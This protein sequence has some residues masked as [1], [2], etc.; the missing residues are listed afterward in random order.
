MPK[1]FR[2]HSEVIQRNA[3]KSWTLLH[4][5]IEV[6]LFGE[7]EGV[8]DVAGELGIRHEL[9]VKRNEFGTPLLDSV[10]DRAH[11]IARHPI[12]CYV[13]CDIVLLH[14]FSDAVSKVAAWRDQFLMVGRRWDTDVAELIDFSPPDWGKRLR[15]LALQTNRQ[16]SP[17]WIDYFAFSRGLY[18]QQVPPFAIGRPGYDQWMVWF[19]RNSRAAVVDASG[20]VVAVH[21]NHDYSHH[22]L[23]FQGVMDGEEAQSNARL[24]GG[25][26]HLF[27]IE[28]AQYLLEKEGVKRNYRRLIADFKVLRSSA[29]YGMLG[30]T[31]PVRHRLGLRQGFL[32]KGRGKGG[33]GGRA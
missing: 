12:L 6:I 16:R 28:N 4:P 20:S 23:G 33:S 14:D 24:V 22:P 32:E 19:A 1:P 21:Q 15:T 31:R 13:N 26:R 18:H 27:T 5:D 10:L 8:A 9:H 3:I 17:Q 7:E 25:R 11:E 2:G 29:W 30:V